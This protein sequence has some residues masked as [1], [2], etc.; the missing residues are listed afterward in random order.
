MHKS[1]Q[2]ILKVILTISVFLS[3]T[4][5]DSR[6]YALPNHNFYISICEIIYKKETKAL[7]I[8]FRFFIDDFEKAIH[9]YSNSEIFN[10]MGEKNAGSDKFI[11]NY[12]KDNFSMY[13]KNNQKIDYDFVGWESSDELCWCYVES[14]V[15]KLKSLKIYNNLLTEMFKG[16]KN[17][18]YLKFKNNETS[19]LLDIDKKNGILE[20]E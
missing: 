13:N 18:V 15:K 17:L 9:K 10:S 16:Q 7:E 19:I 5:L 11:F 4:L 14:S 2:I 6:T 1:Y 20:L 3:N 8:S 12:L